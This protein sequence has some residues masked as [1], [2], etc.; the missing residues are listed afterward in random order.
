MALD[1]LKSIEVIEAMEKFIA[2][3]RP[4][5]EL[6]NKVDLAYKTEGQ[7]VI[8]FEIRPSWNDQSKLI[9]GRIAKAT[10]IN[11]QKV[12]KVFWLRANLKWYGYEPHLTV[13]TIEE[14][15]ELVDKDKYG[16]FFG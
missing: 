9:E 2:K 1:I 13:K 12:W 14:F 6:R 3:R 15:V 16:C 8:I 11:S 5:I 7:S 4:P 10:Y